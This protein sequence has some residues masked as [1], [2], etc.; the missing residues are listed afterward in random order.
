MT[1][2]FSAEQQAAL[3]AMRARKDAKSSTSILS[4]EERVR[5]HAEETYR[6]QVR[7]EYAH[8]RLLATAPSY[9]TGFVLNLLVFGLG[10][11]IIGEWAWGIVWF[12]TALAV[13]SSLY[14]SVWLFVIAWPIVLLA[15]LIHYRRVYARK[16]ATYP[17][18]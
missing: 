13:W 5:I 17:M 10:F 2:Q 3:D 11:L 8:H 6:A 15:P 12:F 1:T 16:Y 7:S 9:W 18:Y 4:A 14:V